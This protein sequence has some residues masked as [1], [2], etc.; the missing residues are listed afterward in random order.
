MGSLD[1][2]PYMWRG[3]WK[4]H[5]EG[6]RNRKTVAPYI[7]SVSAGTRALIIGGIC[8]REDCWKGERKN[9]QLLMPDL[10]AVIKYWSSFSTHSWVTAP[11]IFRFKIKGTHMH[12]PQPLHFTSPLPINYSPFVT[13]VLAVSFY[14]FFVSLLFFCGHALFCVSLR[15]YSRLNRWR[16]DMILQFF[17]KVMV[18]DHANGLKGVHM[19]IIFFL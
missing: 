2:I 9:S 5:T 18:F 11:Q 12:T 6:A 1:I 19:F 3:I 15:R 17:V 4:R 14:V 10:A 13:L 16:N 8:G 7:V